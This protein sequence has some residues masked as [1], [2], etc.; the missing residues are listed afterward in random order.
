MSFILDALKKAE[1]ERQ[2][3]TGP[4]LLEVRVAQPRRRF[5]TWTIVI[6]ALLAINI[7]LLI[8]FE[9]R[10]PPAGA[11]PAASA[12][13][14]ATAPVAAAPAAVP[15]A[16]PAVAATTP[17]AAARSGTDCRGPAG[18]PASGRT[19]H[20]ATAT[21]C[22]DGGAIKAARRVGSGG[23]QSGR[24]RTSGALHRAGGRARLG[25]QLI[26]AARASAE[27]VGRGRRYAG[28]AT[29]PARVRGAAGGS[30][31]THQY[32][33]RARRGCAA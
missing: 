15:S 6:G 24:L 17:A 25:R 9:L 19:K 29:G 16:A 20:R 2:R 27:P 8:A 11:E 5:P 4:T 3:Q 21:R 28:S 7:L 18:D 1:A 22:N 23:G 32:A 12:T 33:S 26:R 30:L 13:P 10:R 31:R 14:A